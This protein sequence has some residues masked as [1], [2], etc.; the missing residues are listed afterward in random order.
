MTGSKLQANQA[1]RG[2]AIEL[3]ENS[4][5]KGESLTITGN[6]AFSSAGA[7]YVQSYSYLD[8]IES[9]ISRN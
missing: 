8:M 6:V 1:W 2:G 5:F 4:Y 9:V 3:R 7:I